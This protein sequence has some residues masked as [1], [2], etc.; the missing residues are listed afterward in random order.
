L[1]VV[2]GFGGNDVPGVGGDDVG[3]DEVQLVGGIRHS[4]GGYVAFIRVAAFV[5][6]ALDLDAQEASIVFDGEVVAGHVS[7]RLGDAEAMFGGASHKAQFGPLTPR[8]GVLDVNPLIGHG[9]MPPGKLVLVRAIKN[10]AAREAAISY[11][12]L[13]LL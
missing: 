13:R 6:G 11:S 10:A 4:I 8:F 7:P 1:L 9:K 5:L 3:S 2:G 12:T